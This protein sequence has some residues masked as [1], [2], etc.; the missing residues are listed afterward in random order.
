MNLSAADRA[1]VGQVE[2]LNFIPPE[3][4]LQR[5]VNLKKKIHDAFH[6]F[7]RENSGT[8]DV[9]EV[10]TIVRALG[11]NP[12]ETQMHRIIEEIEEPEPT[13]WIR[14]EKFERLMV[15]VLWNNEFD[16]Q[17]LQR[18]DEERILQAFAA[19]DPEGNGYIDGEMLQNMLTSKGERFSQDE[20]TEFIN[21]AADPETGHIYYEEYAYVLSQE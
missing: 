18:D 16:G 2:E 3:R 10:G 19:L 17:V 12:T 8:C 21:A 20:V 1:L 5:K 4:Q 13:G 6:M 9:R 11:I 14:Y 15:D 7:E